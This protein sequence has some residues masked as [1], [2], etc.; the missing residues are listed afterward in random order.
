VGGSDEEEGEEKV[1]LGEGL[2]QGPPE[3]EGGGV[4]GYASAGQRG[5]EPGRDRLG[6][7]GIFLE[8]RESE[9]PEA[10]L[11][12]DDGREQG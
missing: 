6:A 1:P 5:Q 9:G 8:E 11:V 7:G 2:S 4:E 12:E 10:D 3:G